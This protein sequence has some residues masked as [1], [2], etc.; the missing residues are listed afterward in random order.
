M[1]DDQKFIVLLTSYRASGGGNVQ[2]LANAQPLPLPDAPVRE[3]VER[4]LTQP[5]PAAYQEFPWRFA[6]LGSTPALFPTGPGATEVMSE[7]RDLQPL[8]G[9][10]DTAGFLTLT[11]HL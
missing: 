10:T 5:G 2:A 7:I 1:R 8:I 6:D 3:A 4:Q 11:L 9:T